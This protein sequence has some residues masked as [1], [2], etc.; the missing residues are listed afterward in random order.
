MADNTQDEKWLYEIK[1]KNIKISEPI[2]DFDF[3]LNTIRRLSWESRG[4][5]VFRGQG[6]AAHRLIPSAYRDLGRN[7]FGKNFISD[8]NNLLNMRKI[9]RKNKSINVI[10]SEVLNEVQKDFEFDNFREFIREADR[11]AIP[12]PEFTTSLKSK[13]ICDDE[14]LKKNWPPHELYAAL[15]LAQHAGIPTRLLDWTSDIYAALYF[16]A[17]DACQ[18]KILETA[19]NFIIWILHIG[20]YIE[21]P[22]IHEL[23]RLPNVIKPPFESIYVPTLYNANLAAQ[24]GLFIYCPDIQF[25]K[26]GVLPIYDLV[27]VI[28]NLREINMIEP[29]LEAIRI[30]IKE[31]S[32]LLGIIDN[33]G[34][35]PSK[36][37]PGLE[38]VVKTLKMRAN[39]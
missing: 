28:S 25:E 12:I 2:T 3:L 4:K 5:L 36:Y 11:R 39:I 31:A 34:H 35:S 8:F 7:K 23:A 18:N 15:G 16:A 37:F 21:R 27:K 26:Y 20:P 10:E 1:H 13:L 6:N 32:T 19:E 30:P 29:Y 14:E 24:Q 9:I 38:G 33:E 22:S 17:F